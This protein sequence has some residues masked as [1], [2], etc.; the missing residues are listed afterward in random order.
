MRRVAP[1]PQ[2]P[3]MSASPAQSQLCRGRWPLGLCRP[4]GLSQA[5]R[6]AGVSGIIGCSCGVLQSTATAVCLGAIASLRVRSGGARE[7][8]VGIP[9]SPKGRLSGALPTAPGVGLTHLGSQQGNPCSALTG[10]CPDNQHRAR[11]PS[12]VLGHSRSEPSSGHQTQP[13]NPTKPNPTQPNYLLT[14]WARELGAS[15]EPYRHF[16]FLTSLLQAAIEP[17]AP[18]PQGCLCPSLCQRLAGHQP[19]LTPA[20]GPVRAVLGFLVLGKDPE[21]TLPPAHLLQ[22]RSGK[23]LAPSTG[24]YTSS[25]VSPPVTRG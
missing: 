15:R 9:Q 20:A 7:N 3:G 4:R 1:C 8:A 22:H 21:P 14:P 6:G 11:P 5:L 17:S 25:S 24:P 12:V 13:K 18:L 19:H 2:P 16:G 10:S 23:V